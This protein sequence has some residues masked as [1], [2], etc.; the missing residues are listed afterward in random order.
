MDHAALRGAVAVWEPQPAGCL[1]PARWPSRASGALTT[2]LYVIRPHR[3]PANGTKSIIEEE[4]NEGRDAG[5]VAQPSPE[6]D[7]GRGSSS[8]LRAA[9]PRPSAI[10]ERGKSSCFL[11]PSL[12][13]WH[14]FEKA[15]AA[16]LAAEET[17]FADRTRDIIYLQS[18][19]FGR[20]KNKRNLLTFFRTG[21]LFFVFGFW[22]WSP[23]ILLLHFNTHRDLFFINLCSSFVCPLKLSLSSFYATEC[24]TKE[25]VQILATPGRDRAAAKD[26]AEIQ[27]KKKKKERETKQNEAQKTPPFPLLGHKFHFFSV[28][29]FALQLLLT[30]FNLLPFLSCRSSFF[31]FFKAMWG[32][33][34][35]ENGHWTTG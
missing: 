21:F 32:F 34:F 19:Y 1:P 5:R 23:V 22:F 9:F 13:T 2:Q 10:L 15:S 31:F 8:L 26:P 20:E 4:K 14:S 25:Y 28:A 27:K 30:A 24:K 12:T 17:R 16:V 35:P 7:G 33:H 29:S 11:S 3:E 18:K 6:R